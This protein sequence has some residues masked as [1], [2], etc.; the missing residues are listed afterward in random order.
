M[1]PFLLI[2]PSFLVGDNP[3][4]GHPPRRPVGQGRS[5]ENPTDGKGAHLPTG[6]YSGYASVGLLTF[7][8]S[9]TRRNMLPENIVKATFEGKQTSYLRENINGTE[10]VTEQTEIVSREGTNIL[11]ILLFFPSSCFQE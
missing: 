7:M 3:G 4:D 6:Y 5:T 10:V 8:K 1:S 9:V 11:G 2:K